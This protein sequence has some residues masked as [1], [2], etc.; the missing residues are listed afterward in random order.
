MINNEI[1]TEFFSEGFCLDKKYRK[2][3]LGQEFLSDLQDGFFP[4]ELQTKYP[5]GCY[6][7]VSYI[8]RDI[9]LISAIFT[10]SYN[11]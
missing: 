5:N 11:L 1:S 6:F 10:L 8:K 3:E 7:N 9:A 4:S 2:Y